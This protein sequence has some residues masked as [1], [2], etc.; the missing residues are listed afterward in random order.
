MIRNY[1]TRLM[2]CIPGWFLLIVAWMEENNPYNAVSSLEWG[3]LMLGGI[4]GM[5]V[6]ILIIAPFKWLERKIINE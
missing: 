3:G 2:I 5:V 6:C 1:L 4:C